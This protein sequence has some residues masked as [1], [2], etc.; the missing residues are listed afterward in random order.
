MW[1]ESRWCIVLYGFSNRWIVRRLGW[2]IESSDQLEEQSVQ[3]TEPGA[4]SQVAIGTMRTNESERDQEHSGTR[5]SQ[6]ETYDD[7][8]IESSHDDENIIYIT[9]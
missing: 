9:D 8:E 7:F 5:D 4:V 6:D 3:L 2:G 1:S